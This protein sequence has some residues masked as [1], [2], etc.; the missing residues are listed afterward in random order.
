[1]AEKHSCSIAGAI[2]TKSH[3]RWQQP[4]L[5]V[6]VM[7]AI[8]RKVCI[9]PKTDNNVIHPVA[10]PGGVSGVQTPAPSR[11]SEGPP[12]SCQTQTD[13]ENC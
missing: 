9:N 3:V 5:D 6:R 1:M 10:C 2:L 8:E 7:C 12:K 4:K 13:C 11:N